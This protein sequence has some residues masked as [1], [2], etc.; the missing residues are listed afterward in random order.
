VK[1]LLS[2]VVTPH[3]DPNLQPDDSPMGFR[4]TRTYRWLAAPA[5][6]CKLSY[7]IRGD[8]KIDRPMCAYFWVRR[9][10]SWLML[11]SRW[12]NR[13]SLRTLGMELAERDVNRPL[14]LIQLPEA[15]QGKVD[16]LT[17]TDSGGA[18]E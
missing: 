3:S 15:I 7:P 1:V 14:V 6:L 2:A 4:L 5:S 10:S 12:V 17:D 9:S 13:R 16:T 11:N 8:V 18:D